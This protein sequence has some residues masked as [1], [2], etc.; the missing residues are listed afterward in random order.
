M[1]T[2]N[3]HN[4]YSVSHIAINKAVEYI[5]SNLE[6]KLDTKILSKVCSLSPTYFHDVFKKYIKKTPNKYITYIRIK[7]AKELIATTNMPIYEIALKCGF[8]SNTYFNYVFKK[9]LNISPTQFRNKF[10]EF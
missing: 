8:E 6:N 4:L 1:E 2:N 7:K 9:E 10:I 5:H 3:I